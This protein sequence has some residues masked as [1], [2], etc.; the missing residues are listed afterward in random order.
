MKTKPSI[1]AISGAIIPEPLAN[2]DN[3][4]SV[5]P[6]FTLRVAP[7]GKVSVVM[8]ASAASFQDFA[9]SDFFIVPIL[10]AM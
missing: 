4:T 6:M 3:V 10:L 7:L 8:M 5:L 9:A 1:V 2:P